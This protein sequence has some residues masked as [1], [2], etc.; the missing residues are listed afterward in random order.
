MKGF[1]GEGA[2]N[3]INGSGAAVG[4]TSTEKILLF[5]S[6]AWGCEEVKWNN[7]EFQGNETMGSCT[8]TVRPDVWL[9]PNFGNDKAW[10]A[11]TN[12]ATKTGFV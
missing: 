5:F 11:F 1:Q 12:P 6:T 7:E 8:T 10:N 2:S 9:A 4:E 3:G